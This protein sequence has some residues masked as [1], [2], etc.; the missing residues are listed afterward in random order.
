M[1]AADDEKKEETI[2][3]I[4]FGFWDLWNYGSMEL[5]VAQDAISQSILVLFQQ[6]DI[7]AEHS[8]SDPQVLITGLW[9]VSFSPHFQ[10]L[11]EN[12]TAFHFGEVQHKMIYLVKYWNSALIQAST[13]W[14]KGDVFYL[15]WQSWVMDQIRIT[16]M[17]EL[18]IVDS[19]GIGKEEVI[20]DDV[21]RPCLLG[22]SSNND[23]TSSQK[24][25]N[26]PARCLKPERNLFWY[27]TY[28]VTHL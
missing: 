26:K 15:N 21:L 17:H 27:A 22:S 8:S 9:D 1:Q 28:A 13:N 4:S 3:T 16:Q 7:I 5:E 14:G 24:G 12:N 25:V 11:S 6:L 10:S 18:K 20:F 2:F 19:S 23:T